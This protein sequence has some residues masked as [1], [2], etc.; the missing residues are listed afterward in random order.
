MVCAAEDVNNSAAQWVPAACAHACGGIG[1]CGTRWRERADALCEAAAGGVERH[2][3]DGAAEAAA[4]P[5]AAGKLNTTTT[6]TAIAAAAAAAAAEHAFTAG[7]A[8]GAGEAALRAVDVVRR[9][10]AAAHGNKW[11]TGDEHVTA[12]HAS[13]AVRVPRST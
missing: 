13:E 7:S 12:G 10:A 11:C 4:M 1:A 5:G 9:A 3:A 8:G 2:A 6:T